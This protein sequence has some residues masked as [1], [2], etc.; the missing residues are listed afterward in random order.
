PPQPPPTEPPTQTPTPTETPVGMVEVTIELGSFL[1]VE[2]CDGIGGKGD[3]AL[4]A[5]PTGPGDTGNVPPAA[6]VG[7]A[8]EP[9][10]LGSGDNVRIDREFVFRVP[11]DPEQ[12]YEYRVEFW[13]HEYDFGLG[14][15]TEDDA[16]GRSR[17][18]SR[19]HSLD[20][21]SP[22]LGNGLF[23][24][25]TGGGNCVL[26]LDYVYQARPIAAA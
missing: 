1:V 13:G 15:Q 26:R 2:D 3:F 14:G 17:A 22:E 10:K 18:D 7:S 20:P 19:T 5:S 25:E 23:N 12:R 21:S 24:L 6:S 9:R 11:A 8:D 16:L 4:V